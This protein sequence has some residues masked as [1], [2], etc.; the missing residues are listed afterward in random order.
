M[1]ISFWSY[2]APSLLQSRSISRNSW[3]PLIHLYVKSKIVIFIT[4]IGSII[5]STTV[6]AQEYLFIGGP[7]SVWDNW[8]TAITPRM[9]FSNNVAFLFGSGTPLVDTV[10]GMTSTP[11]NQHFNISSAPAWNAILTDPH[12][13]LATNVVGGTLAVM[14]ASANGSVSYN[15]SNP[16]TV[17]NSPLSGTTTIFLIAWPV[18]FADPFTAAS[19]GAPVGWS[20]PF[21]YPI[22]TPTNAPANFTVNGLIPFGVDVLPEP[23]TITLLAFGSAAVIIFRRRN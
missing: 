2:I 22:G 1:L 6:F 18:F 16:F 11:T 4:F 21:T 3:Q 19:V 5:Y 14:R 13:Q 23:T 12:F 9:D 17:T 20:A 15:G 10:T 8:S 7:R